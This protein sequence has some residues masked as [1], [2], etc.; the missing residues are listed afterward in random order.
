[1]CLARSS[2]SS[3]P[4]A[5]PS[6]RTVAVLTGLFMGLT[7]AGTVADSH[8]VPFSKATAKLLNFPTGLTEL[9]LDRIYKINRIFSCHFKRNEVKSRLELE[10]AIILGE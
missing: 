3:E 4:A 8:S 5:F 2:D 7:A 1:M 10:K 6:L 9:F